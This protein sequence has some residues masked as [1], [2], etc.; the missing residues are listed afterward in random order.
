MQSSVCAGIIS[1]S[2]PEGWT[3]S[4]HLHAVMQCGPIRYKD[5]AR[6]RAASQ[7]FEH[8]L[9]VHR[10]DFLLSLELSAQDR[11]AIQDIY[12]AIIA[13]ERRNNLILDDIIAAVE[14]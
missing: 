11:P 13:D 10:T 3:P 4:Y 8:K 7:P 6:D 2:D 1:N 5:N 12:S 9:I 14:E